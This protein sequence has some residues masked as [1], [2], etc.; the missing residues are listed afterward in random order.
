VEALEVV[1]CRG[2]RAERVERQKMALDFGMFLHL[3][4]DCAKF[5]SSWPRILRSLHCFGSL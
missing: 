3:L 4:G 1:K 5:K 2:T